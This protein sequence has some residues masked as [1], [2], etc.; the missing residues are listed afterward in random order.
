[1][2]ST[3][4]KTVARAGLARLVLGCVLV[5]LAATRVLAAEDP[6]PRPAELERDV[7]FWIHVYSE[8]DTNGGFLHDE[9]N[10]AVVYEK[11]HFAPNTSPR[12]REKIVDQGKAR[13]AA[14]LRRIAA[15]NGGPLSEDD[16]RILDM[17]GSEGTPGR[18]LAAADE[19]RFQLGPS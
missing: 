1:M 6:M 19:I 12:E 16:Q 14:A 17:W 18:L 2:N 4:G 5:L 11:L 10:L 13:Y 3:W 9:H 15:A 8:V 7:Q